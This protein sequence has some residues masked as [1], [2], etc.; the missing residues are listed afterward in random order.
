[1]S[2]NTQNLLFSHIC[3]YIKQQ[4]IARHEIYKLIFLIVNHIRE[5]GFIVRQCY[6]IVPEFYSIVHE[7]YLV[8]LLI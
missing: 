2:L 4:V 3:S 7:C 8:F 1:M 6:P 5:Y